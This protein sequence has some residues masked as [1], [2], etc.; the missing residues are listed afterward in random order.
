MVTGFILIDGDR[1]K[2][3]IAPSTFLHIAQ[4]LGPDS[5]L[6]PS[7]LRLCITGADTYLPYLH[8]FYTPSLKTLEATYVPDHQHPSFFSF[9][10][11]LVHKVP[12]LENIILGPD[13]FPLKSLQVV[14][15]FAYLRQLELRDAVLTID[16]TFLQDVGSLPNLECLILDARSCE[17][18][19]RIPED[20]SVTPLTEHMA[21]AGSRPPD[22]D[23]DE[24]FDNVTPADSGIHNDGPFTNVHPFSSRP[25]SPVLTIY[26]HEEIDHPSQLISVQTLDDTKPSTLAMG[27]FHQL[28]RFHV[29]G[30]LPLVQDMI[31]YIASNILEDIS[32]T[33]IRLSYQDLSQRAEEEEKMRRQ[34]EA[35][36]RRQKGKEERRQAE[37]EEEERERKAEEEERMRCQTRIKKKKIRRQTEAGERKEEEERWQAKAEERKQKE[38]E[39]MRQK[40]EEEMR[41]KAEEEERRQ[42]AEE[43][44]R[45]KAE[46]E[47][48]QKAEEEKR[49]QEAVQ[50]CPQAIFDFHT[51]SYITLLQTVSSRWSAD[52]KV[53][54][55]NQLDRSSHPLSIP[56][57]LPKQVYE[58]LLRHPRLEIL[59]CKRW[60]L[61]SVQD[62]LLSLE[63]SGSKNLK[64]LYLPIDGPNPAVSLS[65]LL[66]IARAFPMLES[67]QCCIDTL[68][69]IP[70]YSIPTTSA[71]SHG[72]QALIIANNPTSHW[73]FNQL[74]LVARHLYLMFPHIQTID[75]VEGLK[76]EQWLHICELVEMFQTIHKDDLYRFS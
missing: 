29:I 70:Q 18:V 38:E 66:Y 40:A 9:L 25:T 7:L 1:V 74:L 21:E 52:L 19:A 5:C 36:E 72:L 45:R 69:P 60:K 57:A 20:K 49:Q 8:L 53:V 15:E 26:H 68:S 4:V 48:K 64:Q 50:K 46:E 35:E 76:A 11:T 55:F 13:K 42:K 47:R 75:N 58:T 39:E 31:P 22:I 37:F 65:G 23:S 67:L 51:A 10:T 41:Q 16:F 34:A 43:G 73:D 33:V 24:L 12:L 56:P 14:L 32:I 6:L 71:L 3:D 63:L 62:F 30:G 2:P 59:D 44:R 27:G 28:K 61:D 17:Y 54:K